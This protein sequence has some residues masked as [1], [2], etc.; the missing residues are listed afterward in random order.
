MVSKNEMA[1]SQRTEKAMMRAMCGVKMIEKKS[2]ELMSL[3]GL[4]NTLDGLARASGVPWYGHVLRR[5]N[6]D[7]L[8][9][10]LDFEVAGK[11]G[12]PNMMWKRQ[13]EEHI[14]QIGLKRNDAIDRVKWRNG[15][16][17]LSRSTR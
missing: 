4:E 2:Q 5:D 15:V 10:A 11:S 9:R 16:Y 7:A 12:R 6:G 14:E 1:I 17:E 3:L 8:R 13:V